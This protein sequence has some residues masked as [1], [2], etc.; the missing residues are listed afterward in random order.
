MEHEIFICDGCEYKVDGKDGKD[1]KD[2]NKC[3]S[4]IKR[5]LKKMGYGYLGKDDD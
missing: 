2:F 5:V 3:M 1:C 4:T